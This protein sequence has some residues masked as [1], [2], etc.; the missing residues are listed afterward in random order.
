MVFVKAT[1]WS[2][3]Y[4][5]HGGEVQLWIVPA[6]K[7]P[8]ATADR[9]CDVWYC[10]ISRSSPGHVTSASG[11]KILI[12]IYTPIIST[13]FQGHI[14]HPVYCEKSYKNS[15]ESSPS[16]C[17][18]IEWLG[19]MLEVPWRLCCFSAPL[20]I[21]CLWVLTIYDFS[22]DVSSPSSCL[23]HLESSWFRVVSRCREIYCFTR[24]LVLV[25]E[26]GRFVYYNLPV[27]IKLREVWYCILNSNG[28]P[29]CKPLSGNNW[30]DWVTMR[31]L[32]L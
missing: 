26:T 16:H 28:V 31:K 9:G 22:I 32:Y 30:S 11:S 1:I 8:L 13:W 2:W 12:Y 5:S 7:P 17:I 14:D 29:C 19:K 3:F 23:I 6:L 18:F 21:C 4:V 15:K 20:L 25:R 27:P 10:W 24:I